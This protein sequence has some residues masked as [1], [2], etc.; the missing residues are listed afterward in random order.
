LFDR[1]LMA[2]P[3]SHETRRNIAKSLSTRPA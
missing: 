3:M 2:L 1:R